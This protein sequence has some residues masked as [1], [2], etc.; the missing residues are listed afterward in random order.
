MPSPLDLDRLALRIERLQR[1]STS[2][3]SPG[4]ELELRQALSERNRNRLPSPESLLAHPDV[5]EGDY[6]I[7]TQILLRLEGLV[8]A[9]DPRNPRRIIRD[10]MRGKIPGIH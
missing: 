1:M 7:W 2:D 4:D 8:H 9:N 5:S 6:R 10:I 3:W